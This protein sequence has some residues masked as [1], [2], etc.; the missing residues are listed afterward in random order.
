MSSRKLKN[1]IRAHRK[2]SWLSQSEVAMLAGTILMQRPGIGAIIGRPI[3]AGVR[4]FGAR[5]APPAI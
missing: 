1:Y 3:A 5:F 2:R 4:I